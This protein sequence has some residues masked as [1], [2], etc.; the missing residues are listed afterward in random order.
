[1]VS[2]PSGMRTKASGITETVALQFL[3]V[4]CQARTNL[5]L[6]ASNLRP[7]FG[8]AGHW[9]VRF[10]T[11]KGW[12]MVSNPSGMRTKR[13]GVRGV[14]DLQVLLVRCH[15]RKNLVLSASSLSRPFGT[16]GC[17]GFEF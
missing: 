17:G 3:L 1:M 2:N 14:G 9:R 12:A 5:V 16:V 7:P 13:G 4:R 10:P 15:A 11:L 8:T 6:A